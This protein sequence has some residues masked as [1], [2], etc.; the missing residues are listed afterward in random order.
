MHAVIL[1]DGEFPKT[2][3]L[4]DLLKNSFVAVCDG[5]IYNLDKI[6]IQPNIIVGDLDGISCELKNKYIDK[7]IHIKE[8]NTNDLSKTFSYCLKLGFDT[9]VILGATG[10]RED[11][12]VA[13]ISLLPKLARKCKSVVMKSDYGEFRVYLTPCKV[14]SMKGQQISIFCFDKDVN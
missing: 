13:N 2:Q 8:Q 7:I 4:L 3:K 14:E 9:F 10:K 11:H 6:N 12:T 5:A 1:A